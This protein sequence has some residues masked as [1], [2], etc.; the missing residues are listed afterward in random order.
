MFS[1]VEF[2]YTSFKSDTQVQIVKHNTEYNIKRHYTNITQTEKARERNCL[3]VILFS[4]LKRLQDPVIG[5]MHQ[6]SE[7]K[8]R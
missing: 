5:G 6:K 1:T 4:A 7:L 3:P 2:D 8:S